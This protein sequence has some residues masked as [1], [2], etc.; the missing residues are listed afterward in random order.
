MTQPDLRS[1][2]AE[3]SWLHFYQMQRLI[4]RPPMVITRGAGAKVY[5]QDGKE[6]IDALAGL[7]CVNAGYGREAIARAMYEQATKIHYVSSFSYPNEPAVLVAEK[8]A[9]LAPVAGDGDARV[10]FVSGGSEAVESARRSAW[11]IEQRR[12]IGGGPED[13]RRAELVAE[14]AA[15]RRLA[16]ELER[17]RAESARPWAHCPSPGCTPCAR[18]SSPWC[19][20]RAMRR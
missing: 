10:F 12:A 20:A 2:I 5:D 14:I 8:L 15:E 11:M 1:A 3:H 6:Y 7:F 4:D 16:Q 19:P 17:R 13:A 18:P 9:T